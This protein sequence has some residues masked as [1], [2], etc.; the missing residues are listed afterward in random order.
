[1]ASKRT[2]EENDTPLPKRP[3]L[4][5]SEVTPPIETPRFVAASLI[6]EYYHSALR[7]IH[8]IPSTKPLEIE[9]RL[10]Q[11]LETRSSKFRSGVS[12][13]KAYHW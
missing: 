7:E 8:Q 10:G 4:E 3:R 2:R 6:L 11:I 13:Y 5:P 1:M 12:S 9:V